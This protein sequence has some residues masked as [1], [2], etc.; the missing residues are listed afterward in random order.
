VALIAILLP[1]AACT[2]Y[3]GNAAP[4]LGKGGNRAS[5]PVNHRYV[6]PP[7]RVLVV[8]RGDTVYGISRRHGVPMREVISLNNL[9]APYTL[10]V[11][12]RLQM[13][14][15]TVYVV[16]RGDTFYSIARTHDVDMHALA[17]V[18]GLGPPYPL[19]V[20]QR[21]VVPDRGRSTQIAQNRAN[22]AQTG[23]SRPVQ[24]RTASP[25]APRPSPPPR[26][27][28]S[29]GGGDKAST[30]PTPPP[31]SGVRFSWPVRGKVISKFGPAG[32]GLRNDGIN[33]LVEHGAPVRA[34]ENG[35]VVYAG[36]ELKGFGNLLL[37]KHE[38]G[39][40]TA[41]AH[42]DRLLVRRG[43]KVKRG[44]A[45]AKAGRTGNVDRPQV[46]FEIRRGD[47]AVDPLKHLERSVAA[48]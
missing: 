36:N 26:Q 25:P 16:R 30:I 42:N 28:A 14:R 11:G 33:I 24:A 1:L 40:M 19:S 6:G 38:G 31:R 32:K 13:P 21:L 10:Y 41:Y 27:S 2:G 4:W 46:H 39:W 17:R 45:I 37:L 12:Q 23:V 5:A 18:N 3:G 44:Q 29:Q 15:P 47:K 9:Q 35:V 22:P 43:D 20:G 34:A 48:R 8:Q 7:P